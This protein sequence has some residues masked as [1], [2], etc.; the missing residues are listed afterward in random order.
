M[1][2]VFQDPGIGPG[3]QALGG[4]LGQVLQ[5]IGKERRE[6]EKT[7]R[8]LEQYQK[9]KSPGGGY[10][11]P[12]SDEM[13]LNKEGEQQ[14]G[15]PTQIPNEMVQQS[16]N[17]E[18]AAVTLGIL[19]KTNKPLADALQKQEIANQK[20]SAKREERDYQINKPLY[21]DIY[22]L[23]SAMPEKR[24]VLERIEDAL[25]SGQI[26]RFTD[27]AAGQLGLDPLKTSQGQILESAVKELFLGDLGKIKGGRIN[28][29]IEKNLLGALQNAGKS[30][31]ANQEITET[32]HVVQDML[33][34]RVK[35]FDDITRQ[36]ERAGREPGRSL[37]RQVDERL[38]PIYEKKMNELSKFRKDISEGKILNN[39][40]MQMRRAKREIRGNPP[41]QGTKWVINPKGE[42]VAIPTARVQDAINGGGRL[43]N[44]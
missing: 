32:L 36:Y 24:I 26:N 7:Q 22:K 17:P 41:P 37:A 9:F 11:T 10:G 27:W 33:Q 34:E 15:V 44:E 21:E 18:A 35:A 25:N 16:P 13:M 3:L 31:G 23:R 12:S 20:L 2:L 40:Q 4:S 14:S 6:Q 5:E 30:R 38:A 19:G 28:Q 39:E 29:L 43:V 8:L 42:V 1:A